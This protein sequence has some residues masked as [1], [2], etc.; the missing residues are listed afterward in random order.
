MSQRG[1]AKLRKFKTL[2]NALCMPKVTA[3]IDAVLTIGH[4]VV[5]TR[6]NPAVA[7]FPAIRSA[8]DKGCVDAFDVGTPSTRHMLRVCLG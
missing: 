2:A 1:L 5:K 3:E 4:S 7:C 8:T 6:I